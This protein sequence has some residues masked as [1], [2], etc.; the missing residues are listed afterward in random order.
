MG[1]STLHFHGETWE[2]AEAIEIEKWIRRTIASFLGVKPAVIDVGMPISAYGV[3]SVEA[4]TLAG[5]L[6]WWL[7]HP[8]PSMLV[9]ERHSTREIALRLAQRSVESVA[10][11]LA[12]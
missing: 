10:P 11:N 12:S 7:G 9:S 1:A 3:D 5:E 4:A 8:V 6:E 2:L